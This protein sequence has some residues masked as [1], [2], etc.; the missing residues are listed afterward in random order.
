MR[1]AVEA[2][3]AFDQFLPGGTISRLW[4]MDASLP[5]GTLAY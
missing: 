5:A 1:H 3:L 4:M 2:R